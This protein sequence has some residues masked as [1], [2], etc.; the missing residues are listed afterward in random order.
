MSH[1]LKEAHYELK[2]V[3]RDDDWLRGLGLLAFGLGAARRSPRA[4]YGHGP[5]HAGALTTRLLVVLL[6]PFLVPLVHIVRETIGE[7]V[8]DVLFDGGRGADIGGGVFPLVGRVEGLVVVDDAGRVRS[9]DEGRWRR[10]CR[11]VLD[12]TTESVDTRPVGGRQDLL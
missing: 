8:G 9:R 5:L 2:F 3:V 6:E 4:G 7:T 1:L 12:A 11:F 10:R